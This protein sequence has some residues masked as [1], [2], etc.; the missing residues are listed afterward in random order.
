MAYG[1]PITVS[2]GAYDGN[3]REGLFIES[4]GL[5]TDPDVFLDDVE[6]AM[7]GLKGVHIIYSAPCGT[8][9]GGVTAQV[10]GGL[11]DLNGAYGIYAAVGPQGDLILDAVTPPGFGDHNGTP[12]DSLYDVL[13]STQVVPCPTEQVETKPEPKPYLVIQVPETGGLPVEQNCIDYS[14]TLMILP[15]GGKVLL[16]C[17][18]QGALLADSLGPSELPGSIPGGPVFLS[19]MEISLMDGDQPVRVLTGGGSLLVAFPVP[20]D[21]RPN[22][23]YAILYWD[24]AA[25]GGVGGWVELPEYRELLPGWPSVLRL[26]PD[27]NPDDLMRIFSGVRALGGYIKARVNFPGTFVLVRR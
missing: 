8:T 4:D 15:D 7:N 16:S 26:H 13:V 21:S 18:A 10:T 25:Q 22:D 14:G 12:T 3:S 17:P 24:A 5:S 23:R 19:A 6:A 9:T 1:S 11:Y 20:E 2:G 27:A